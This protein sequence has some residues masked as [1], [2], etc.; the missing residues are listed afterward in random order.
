[1]PDVDLT[2]QTIL[3]TGGA[4]FIGSHLADALV[5]A[6]DVTILDDLSTGARENVPEEATFVEG[7]VRDEQTVAEVADD[8]DL[9]FHEAA[10]VSVQQSVEAPQRCHDVTH[11]GTLTILERARHEDARVVFASSAAIYGEPSTVPLDETE[12]VDPSSP[13]GIDKCSADQYVRAYHDLYGLETIALRYFNVYGPR[14]TAGDY[15][16]VISIFREQANRD[17]PITVDGD[18]TQTRDFV[19]VEDVVRA[20]CLAATTEHVGTAYNVGTGEETTIRTLAEKIRSIADADSEI[21]HGDPRPG[22]IERSCADISRA[23]DALGYEPTIALGD[24][25]ETLFEA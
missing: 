10:I 8:V 13:Y 3:I 24:G 17:D 19:H 9:I 7:D 2:G 22:D 23:R 5:D 15:S 1:M 25:L 11:D 14:Q 18:G 16:G 20:N 6:N 21:V 12:P 4:G